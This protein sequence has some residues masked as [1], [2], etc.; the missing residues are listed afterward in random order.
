M[1]IF[2]YYV[3]KKF[4]LNKKSTKNGSRKKKLP[5]NSTGERERNKHK[6]I[7]T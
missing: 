2:H 5:R 4:F 6:K 1:I 3:E 7:D